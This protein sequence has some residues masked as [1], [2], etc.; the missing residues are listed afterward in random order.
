MKKNGATRGTPGGRNPW[1]QGG[2]IVG[3]FLM[4]PMGNPYMRRVFLGYNPQE[5][6][7]G[8]GAGMTFFQQN[9]DNTPVVDQGPVG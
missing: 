6:L 8:R 4:Y 9:A 2:V 5:S 1:S 7:D 3:C